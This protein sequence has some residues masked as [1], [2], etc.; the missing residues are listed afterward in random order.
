MEEVVYIDRYYASSCWNN[1]KVSIKYISILFCLFYIE[2]MNPT[3]FRFERT[4]SG[5]TS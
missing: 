3:L 2:F 1:L 5:R 4:Q